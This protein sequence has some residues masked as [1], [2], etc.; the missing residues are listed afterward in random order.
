MNSLN[1]SS[2]STSAPLAKAGF[3]DN[4]D[5]N[6]GRYD[7]YNPTYRT[8]PTGIYAPDRLNYKVDPQG[9]W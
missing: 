2:T 4:Y 3:S 1:F 5:G 6:S 8:G 7:V 9:R